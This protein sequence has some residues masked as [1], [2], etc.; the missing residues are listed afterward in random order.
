MNKSRKVHN[1]TSGPLNCDWRVAT[2]EQGWKM[3]SKNLGFL[4][5]LKKTKT[6]I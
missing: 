1:V 5:T 3:A 6:Q 4:K 2:G